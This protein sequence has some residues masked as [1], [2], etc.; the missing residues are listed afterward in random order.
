MIGTGQ[1]AGYGALGG[2]IERSQVAD[3][4]NAPKAVDHGPVDIALRTLMECV[5]MTAQAV[6][7]AE[8][9]FGSVVRSEPPQAA[10]AG[11][12]NDVRPSSGS[13]DLARGLD[14]LSDQLETIARRLQ[15]LT[16]RCEL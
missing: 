2:G 14:V 8:Q 4:L 7:V 10:Q 13:S 5:Q 12:N 11:T 9:R 15:S 3:R 6:I 16:N 1:D